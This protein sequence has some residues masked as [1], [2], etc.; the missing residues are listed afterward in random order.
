MGCEDVDVE[1]RDGILCRLADQEPLVKFYEKTPRGCGSS[2]GAF[3]SKS[4]GTICC[5]VR[6]D[7]DFTMPS[8][9]PLE[10]R[11]NTTDADQSSSLKTVLPQESWTH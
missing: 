7:L 9:S 10:S 5:F 2:I 8:N 11:T 6:I 4:K 1:V 3:V